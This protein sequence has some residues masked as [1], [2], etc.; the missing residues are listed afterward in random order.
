MFI[1]LNQ[2]VLYTFFK[3]ILYIKRFSSFLGSLVSNFLIPGILNHNFS[4]EGFLHHDYIIEKE[5]YKC[6]FHITTLSAITEL[7]T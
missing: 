6:P 1:G 5:L 2:I 4:D 7:A 3:G